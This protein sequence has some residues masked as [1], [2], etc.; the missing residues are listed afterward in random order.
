MNLN[1]LDLQVS[2]VPE[3]AAFFERHF[4]FQIQSNR[5]SAAIVI[6]SDRAGFTLVLQRL[7]DA[8]QGYPNGFHIGFLVEDVALLHEKRARLLESGIE[9]GQ[10]I[11][12][13]RG[14]MFYFTSPGSFL[15]EVGCRAPR[16]VASLRE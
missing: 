1:H 14:V 15:I 12:N 16:R 10:I 6:L 11:E 7:K 2:N 5:T 3:V 4:D 13:N 9:A 8:S